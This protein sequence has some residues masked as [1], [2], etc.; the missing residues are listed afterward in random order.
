[1][2]SHW[3]GS[4][5][6]TPAPAEGVGLTAATVRMFPRLSIGGDTIRVRL[7][8]AHGKGDL[9]IAATHVALRASGPT[10]RPGT[11]Q[12][13]TFNGARQVKI[14]A[15]AFAVSDP[16]SMTVAPLADLAVS[17]HLPKE[18]PASFGVTGRYARQFNHTSELNV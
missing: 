7:S 10:F 1:M 16:L 9:I 3:V 12:Y 11:G 2:T 14:P 5:S 4:W 15:G 18:V 8:N 17:L 6:A 13:A